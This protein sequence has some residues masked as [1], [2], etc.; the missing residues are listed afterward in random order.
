M[1][2]ARREEIRG[3][4][5]LNRVPGIGSV[6]FGRLVEAFGTPAAAFERTADELAAVAGIGDE[7]ARAVASFRD[8]RAVDEEM[9]GAD[10]AGLSYLLWGDESYPEL[11]AA[12][13]DPPPVVRYKGDLDRLSPLA[14]AVVGTRR[15]SAYGE[16]VTAHICRPLAEAGV[17]IVSGM[18]RGIDTRAHE[19]ALRAGGVTVAVLGCG[20][21]VVYPPENRDLYERICER[22]VVLSEFPPGARPEPRN[23]PRRNRIIS[24]LAVGVLVVEAGL[25]SGALITAGN[26]ADQ[27]REVFA[28]PGSIFSPASDG[29]RHLMAGGAK[30]VGTAEEILEEIAP[31]FAG[32]LPGRPVRGEAA[33]PLLPPDEREILHHVGAEAATADDIATK[34]GWPTTRAAAALLALEIA[35]L[36]EKLPGNSYRRVYQ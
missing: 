1:D 5:A 11:L 34:V 29:C 25:R 17:V 21:D 31:Q 35:G 18:A 19:T 2:S 28:V 22:G 20:A 10:R 27:G 32:T 24:G 3:A 13:H 15:L 9:A 16:K 12:T 7:R 8:W 26:A 36:V 14:V 33:A 6:Y 4:L 23:F 30:P